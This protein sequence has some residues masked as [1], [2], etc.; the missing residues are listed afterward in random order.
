MSLLS[1]KT[2][3]KRSVPAPRRRR[4]R[5]DQLIVRWLI[6]LLVLTALTLIAFRFVRSGAL[7]GIELAGEEVGALDE[8]A[9]RERV[10][11]IATEIQA[12]E[13]EIQREASEDAPAESRSYERGE[14][15]YVVDVDATT[16]QILERGRQANPAA[17]LGDQLWAT[18]STVDVDP[19]IDLDEG[20]LDR[21]IEQVQEQLATEASEGG[22][23]FQG[24]KVKATMPRAG[25]T[26]DSETLRERVEENILDD[27][28]VTLTAPVESVEPEMTPADVRQAKRRAEKI[29]SGPI[30]LKH[31]G[32]QARLGKKEIASTLTARNVGDRIRIEVGI[33]RL[34]NVAS[35]S[36]ASL[37]SDPKDA[38]F[39]LSD[40]RVRIVEGSPGAEVDGKTLAASLLRIATSKDRTAPAPVKK[41]QP[42]FS[43]N[44][45]RKLDIDERVS[46][47]TTHHSCCE[48]RVQ[49]IHRIA[50]IIDGTVV[51][52]GET[53]SINDTVGVRTKANGFV[54]A[55]AILDGEYV[56]EVGGGISQFATTIFNAIYF[57]GYQFEEYKAHSYYIS[58][59][60]MGREATV[61]H[62]YPDL[63]FTND[64][65]SGIYID[66]SYTD[67][68]ITVTFY[69]TTYRKVRSVSGEPHNYKRPETQCEENKSLKRGEKRVVQSGSRGFDITVTRIF[70]NGTEEDFHTTYLPVPEIVEK[71]KC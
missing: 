36:L 9:L 26:V 27:Q 57:G 52:P 62:P 63:A 11:E 55:P 32:K 22:I 25:V 21:W 2:P 43:T 47:F 49:N 4:P 51:K 69:G 71:R 68:S 44:D 53:F 65:S 29:V 40:G 7:P 66:T 64:S 60:P 37:S 13:V 41:V 28:E 70:G 3:S 1:K 56:E 35:K 39:E 31:D 5:V 34:Q 67:T 33:E 45:A 19:V 18:F 59:Y 58:R 24:A 46:S 54:G 48:P 10:A 12:E 20:Q 23:E 14:L 15:G 61:S 17:A 6:V 42:E 30:T 50:D 16:E 8:R 38:S